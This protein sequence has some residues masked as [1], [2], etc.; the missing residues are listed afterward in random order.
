MYESQ[1]VD[2]N[3]AMIFTCGGGIMATYGMATAVKAKLPGQVY[4]YDGSWG[5]YNVKKAKEQ[6]GTA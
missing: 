6:E 4:L 2:V 3:K 5:E 1:G